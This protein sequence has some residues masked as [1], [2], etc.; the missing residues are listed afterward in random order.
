[1]L[2]VELTREH[3]PLFQTENFPRQKTRWTYDSVGIAPCFDKI[4]ALHIPMVSTDERNGDHSADWSHQF[5]RIRIENPQTGRQFVS[6]YAV[7]KSSLTLLSED[8]LNP[9]LFVAS[10]CEIP[11]LGTPNFH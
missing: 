9:Y 4:G 7:Q 8:L 2:S 1:M 10:F 5:Y 3:Q 11:L 6:R